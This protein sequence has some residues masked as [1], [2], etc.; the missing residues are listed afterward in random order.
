MVAAPHRLRIER[1]LGEMGTGAVFLCRGVLVAGRADA[2]RNAR[3]GPGSVRNEYASTRAV[4]EEGQVVDC[5]RFAR[6]SGHRYR[7]LSD[8]GKALVAARREMANP[9]NR[10]RSAGATA[11]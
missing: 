2:N 4:L 1:Q 10:P 6:F 7:V 3:H 5:P 8:G 9:R 11:I